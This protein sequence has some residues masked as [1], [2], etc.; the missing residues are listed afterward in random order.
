[1]GWALSRRDPTL[2]I[3]AAALARSG[4]EGCAALVGCDASARQSTA[5]AVTAPLIARI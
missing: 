5:A 3:G 4:P 1:M 2:L